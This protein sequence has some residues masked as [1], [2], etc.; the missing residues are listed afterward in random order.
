M[1]L[2]ELTKTEQFL[3]RWLGREDASSYGECEGIDLSRLEIMGLVSIGPGRN[4]PR[5]GYSAVS[6][7]DRARAALAQSVEK[8]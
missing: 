1:R 4:G 3:L 6:L 7:T 5:D 2:T 8:E